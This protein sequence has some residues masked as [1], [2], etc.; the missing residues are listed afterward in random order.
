MKKKRKLPVKKN[1]VVIIHFFSSNFFETT[2]DFKIRR[3]ISWCHVITRYHD[4]TFAV[5]HI[6]TFS[7]GE[8]V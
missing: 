6:A 3:Q 4:F 2:L 7:G 1:L 5:N 8:L